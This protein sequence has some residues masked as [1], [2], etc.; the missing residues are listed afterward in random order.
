MINPKASS[1]YR[2]QRSRSPVVRWEVSV[3]RKAT[4]GGWIPR[5]LVSASRAL[6][7]SEDARPVFLGEFEDTAAATRNAGKRV[8]RNHHGQTGFFHEQ[9]VDVAQQGAAPGEYDAALRHV[10]AKFRRRLFQRLFDGADY[11]LQWL[12]QRLQYFVGVE[13]ETSRHAFRQIAALDGN[14]AHRL[15]RIGRTDLQL[16]ALRRRFADQDSV[17]A[18][19]VVGDGLVELVAADTHAGR[20]HDAVQG[21]HRHFGGAAADIQHHGT[22]GFL[23]RQARAYRRRHRLRN[24]VHAAR[25]RALRRLLDGA[26]LDLR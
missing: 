24:D 2:T 11:A 5:G 25:A 16:D 6:L 20:I 8:V 12:L 1:E 26:P 14:L 10:G 21:D 18:P 15:A 9:F 13:S 22:A 17:V 4:M 7:Q 23:N 19:Y 3:L